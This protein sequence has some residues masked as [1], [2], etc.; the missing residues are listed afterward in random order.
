V[1][2]F[3]SETFEQRKQKQDEMVELMSQSRGIGLAAPQVG[4]AQNLFVMAT[5]NGII[6]CYNPVIIS[7]VDNIS[8][9]AEGCLSYPG[10]VLNV[11][12]PEAINVKFQDLHGNWQNAS[13]NGIEATC[14]QHELDHLSGVTFVSRVGQVTLALAKKRRLKKKGN[15]A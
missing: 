9:V 10:L 4:L 5:S 2:D 15:Y 11:K 1:Y 13:Y 7:S 8:T 14:F 3:A 12:R 6:S